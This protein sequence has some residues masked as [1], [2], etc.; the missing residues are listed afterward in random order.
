MPFSS[1]GEPVQSVPDYREGFTEN[2]QTPG[3]HP[4]SQ[5]QRKRQTLATALP[6]PEGQTCGL[7]HTHSAGTGDVFL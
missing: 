6:V 3:R 5:V 2:P 1:R 4:G 7:L